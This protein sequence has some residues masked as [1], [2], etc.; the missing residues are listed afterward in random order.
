MA[1]Y[2]TQ[3]ELDFEKEI[4]H[5]LTIGSNQWTERKDLYEATP[6]KLWENFREKL[7]RN[8]IAALKHKEI[9]DEEFNRVKARISNVKS[10]YDAAKILDAEN[11][12]GK[13]EIPRDDASLGT[14]TLNIFWKAD[15]GGGHSSY[16]IVRQAIRP[17]SNDDDSDR[18]FDVT[19]L[20]NGLPL[21]QI[22][23][24]KST[25]EINQAFN[26]IKKYAGENKY[27]DI[28]S[29]LQ[30]FVIMSPDSSAYFANS[31]PD[32]FNKSFV[33]KWRDEDNNPVENGMDF[34]KSALNIPM[35]HKL[36]SEYKAIDEERKK[37]LLLRP[38]QIYAIEAVLKR[39]KEHENGY[40][41]HTTGS[42]KTLTS[43]KTAKLA[44]QM[45]S[46]DRVV[47]LVDRK[48]LDDQTVGN[49][50]AYA[51]NDDMTI[52]KTDNTSK[53]RQALLKGGNNII[54]SSIQK[55]AN[56]VNAEEQAQDEGR[57]TRVAKSKLLDKRIC[58]FVDEAHR[59]QFGK[60]RQDI[61]NAFKNA[62]WYGY[63]GTPIFSEN[64]KEVKG[65]RAVTTQ[66]L[67][68][69][70]CHRYTLVNA[71]EDHAVLPF[72]VEHVNTVTDVDKIVEDKML[73]EKA[74]KLNKKREEL[75]I[76]EEDD[77]KNELSEMSDLQKEAKL[78]K[79][80]NSSN[81]SD[82]IYVN[83]AHLNQVV[84]YILTTGPKKMSLGKGNY[85]GILATSSISMAIRYYQKFN[86]QKKL[87]P[88]DVDKDWPRVAI[89]YSLAENDDAHKENMDGMDEAIAD[90][91]DMFDTNF[92][93]NN[94]EINLYNEDVAKRTARRESYYAHLKR[95][96]EINLVIVVNRLLTG[97]D[98]PKLNT[99]FVDK[100]K[101]DYANLIQA[102]SRTN[103]L[104]NNDLKREGQIVTFRKPVT[105]QQN[106]E[107]AYR[108]YGGEGSYEE[109][110]RPKYMDA[111]A[112]FKSE[113]DHLKRIAP[114]ADSA[115]D[116]KGKEAKANF[117]KT[118]RRVNTQLN[119]L[120]MYNDFTWD[121]AEEEFGISEDEVQ[122]YIGKF[123]RIKSEVQEDRDN[124]DED[125]ILSDLDFSL[126]IGSTVLVDYDYITGLLKELV[127]MRKSYD[128]DQE[129][130][131]NMTDYLQK[132]A[133]I[134]EQITKYEKSG[135]EKQAA[136]LREILSYLDEHVVEPD[137]FDD[138][139]HQYKSNKLN[140]LVNDFADKWG[141]DP[142]E[143]KRVATERHRNIEEGSHLQKLIDH[144]NL[145]HA[146]NQQGDDNLRIPI[147]YNAKANQSINSFIDK[148]IDAYL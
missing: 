45:P 118:F 76:S 115:D 110:I 109:L 57:N 26:Q 14:V 65:D 69:K 13:I 11:G 35:A 93:N 42:G 52:N 41:W 145:D 102:Y 144:G 27:T 103:R 63:T 30:M 106:E 107:N 51:S 125:D 100:N 60:M 23:L 43:Y 141:L 68:G 40:V 1:N 38:Y 134:Q 22:E 122:H 88:N 50:R 96:Q 12:I 8:N 121:N 24:K 113:V 136:L 56:L 120:T 67:F 36:V 129:Y 10:P 147:I 117:V 79:R 80:S 64:R 7:N 16:E 123:Q 138:F 81:P 126:S 46:V 73:K 128:N 98:A 133:E 75:T 108:L 4:V 48:A 25:V 105:S 87:H 132:E 66:E 83:D 59:S 15:V 111:V 91:N 85:N 33:F 55:M 54:I 44:A 29:L 3:S 139:V 71:L 72:N 34:A 140:G 99:L 104:E 19:L 62:N 49:F 131:E 5:Q 94:E 124:D 92:H 21:I 119:S 53:L 127:D 9:T 28:Y 148:E 114:N 77:V 70:E 95:D 78:S 32:E 82:D 89:T 135:H 101:L 37:L 61:S 130:Q 74:S 6:D 2:R 17:R 47:F 31:R 39:I 143:L 84:D 20:I 116:L 58:F 146:A 142:E 18:R 97:F 90:Y 137:K 112:K 86:E